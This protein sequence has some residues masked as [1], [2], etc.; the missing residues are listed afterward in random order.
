MKKHHLGV[1]AAIVLALAGA[2]FIYLRTEDGFAWAEFQRVLS[3]VR[4]GWLVASIGLILI[5][6]VIRAARW[7]VMLRPLAPHPVSLWRLLS[8]TCIGFT[9][10]V[11]FGRAGEPVRP[12]LIARREKVAFSTQ[13]A[14]W[15]VERILDLLM[16]LVIFGLALSQVGRSGL[17]PGPKVALAIQTG[18]WLA[19]VVGLICLATLIG[20][21]V[22][23]GRVKDRLMEALTFV[24]D[25]ARYRIHGF[26]SQFDEGMA[27]TRQGSAVGKLLGYSIVEWTVI[28]GAFYCVFAGFPALDAMGLTDVLIVLGFVAFGS[29]LQIP[30][31][32][33]GMQLTTVLVLTELYGIHVEAASGVALLLWAVNFLIIVPVGLALAFHEGIKW[34]NMKEVAKEAVG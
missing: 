25:T 19:G 33:G 1:L 27:S 4:P 15:L 6:Y 32:G 11:L 16:I 31:V 13:L 7:G 26:L 5:T 18:G 34:R 22:F 17:Q 12:F 10:V 14:A 23:R 29:V 28:A 21:R 30:G 3:G 8:A 24:P 20:L 9:A 2:A